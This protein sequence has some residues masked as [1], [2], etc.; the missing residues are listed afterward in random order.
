MDADMAKTL[1]MLSEA[2][3]DMAGMDSGAA[4][5]MGD[6]I[7][8]KMMGGFEKMGDK[9]DM[10]KIVDDMMKQLLSKEVMYEPMKQ[11][12]DKF[13]EW[14]AENEEQLPAEDYERYSQCVCVCRCV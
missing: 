7:M 4:E 11:I 8:Q 1:Q 2:A 10:S 14:L 6:D 3:M 13:P 5:G 12:C 9:G